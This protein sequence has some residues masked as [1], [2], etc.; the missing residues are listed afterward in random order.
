MYRINQDFVCTAIYK[1]KYKQSRY[2]QTSS[3]K[4]EMFHHRVRVMIE[5]NFVLI[6]LHFK[7]TN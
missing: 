5:E 6:C 1:M 7:G 3:I 4:M 2:K